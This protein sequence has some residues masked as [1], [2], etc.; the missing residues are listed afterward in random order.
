MRSGGIHGFRTRNT[1]SVK[2]EAPRA[3]EK[4]PTSNSRRLKGLECGSKPTTSLVIEDHQDPISC[5]AA[6]ARTVFASHFR[7]VRVL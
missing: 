4:N 5:C 1:F 3:S 6:E 7:T 2:G